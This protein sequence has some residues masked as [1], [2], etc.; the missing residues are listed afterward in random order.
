MTAKIGMIQ[1]A[2][3]KQTVPGGKKGS[4]KAQ[5]PQRVSLGLSQYDDEEWKR[6]MSTGIRT[7]RAGRAASLARVASKPKFVTRKGPL[8]GVI[9]DIPKDQ[10]PTLPVEKPEEPEIL[11]GEGEGTY[12]EEPSSVNVVSDY[13]AI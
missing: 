2:D 10:F 12:E 11:L 5:P 4:K 8:G 6:M 1:L 3:M 7:G 9:I 13:P